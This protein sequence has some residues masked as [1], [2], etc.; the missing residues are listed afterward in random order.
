MS[1]ADTGSVSTEEAVVASWQD[2]LPLLGATLCVAAA[3]YLWFAYHSWKARRAVALAL[4]EGE[5]LR[6]KP[7]TFTAAE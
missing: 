4:A 5:E 1:A 2:T 3:I 6:K 7:R